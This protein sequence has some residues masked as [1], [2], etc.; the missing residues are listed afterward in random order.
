M[1]VEARKKVAELAELSL[2][3]G[4]VSGKTTSEISVLQNE[5]IQ[6]EQ[7]ILTELE[8]KLS[9]IRKQT[10]EAVEKVTL[11]KEQLLDWQNLDKYTE[12]VATLEAE[13]DFYQ[14][15]EVRMNAAKRASNFQSQDALCIRL[16]EQLEAAEQ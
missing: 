2:P 6:K 16:K 3:D 12:E 9:I 1:V 10:S 4:E 5:A 13:K 8:N 11:A 15:M 14:S 7:A